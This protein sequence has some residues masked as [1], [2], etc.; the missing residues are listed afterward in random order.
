MVLAAVRIASSRRSMSR[1]AESEAP[2]AFS[3]S[4]RWPRSSAAVGASPLA[5]RSPVL[6]SSV[7]LMRSRLLDAHGADFFDVR[8][9]GQALLHAV[10]LEGAHAL[11]EADGEHLGDARVLLDRLL[12]AVGGDQQL[13][14]A[15][16]S[17]QAGAAALVAADRLVKRELALVVAVG[18]DPVLVD[19]LHGPLGVGLEPRGAHQ[20]IAVFA[21][22]R[23]ELGRLGRI[24]LLAAAHALGEALR[25]DSK[26]RVGEVERVHAHVE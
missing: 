22:E 16:A 13:V 15:A 7:A 1:S 11:L 9:A 3:C 5:K 10:L 14:Q 8:H 25:E 12:Q 6:E 4:R 20:L 19:R 23:R 24:A 18:L 26:Q 2:M 17:L 21:Q